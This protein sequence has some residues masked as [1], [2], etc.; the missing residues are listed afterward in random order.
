MELTDIKA[1]YKKWFAELK[2]KILSSQIKAAVKVNQEL[3]ALYWWLGQDIA[4][5]QLESS[6][7][8]GFFEQLSKDLKKEFPEMSGFSP[9]N[10]RYAK[11]FYL[12][13][14]QPSEILHQLG[15]NL[16]KEIFSIPWRHHIEIITKCKSI[17]EAIFY[18]NNTLENGWSRAVLMNFLSS[19]LFL[20]QGKATTN[21]NTMLP[22]PMSD[23]AQQTL[24]DPYNFDFLT[25][26]TDYDERELEDALT[27]NITR[28]L[29]EL[30][31]GFAFI[32][33]QVCLDVNGSEFY[34]DLLFYHLNLRCYV[35]IELKVGEFKP[36]HLG[37][38][39]FY[40]TAVDKQIKKDLDNPTIGL[41][42]CK[43]K[44]SV[45]AE[46]ALDSTKSP[47]GISQYELEKLMPENFK[48]NLPTIEE[49]EEQ[50]SQ[51]KTGGYF[52]I[53]PKK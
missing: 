4:E 52:L 39:G 29:L 40:V 25:M 13:Y 22:D 34:I 53:D 20:S 46:Y 35:V 1:D 51:Q 26:R 28:F 15:A 18:V 47:I 32:G 49:I 12:F 42:I 11:K 31:S 27:K 44:N 2:S 37:Q 48:G 3:I 45:V 36:E 41:L 33:R 5:K 6:W 23:L 8:S 7:G 16:R 14:S 43:T 17:E 21:F 38:L 30:G 19:N 24:K 50:L 10:L 9:R